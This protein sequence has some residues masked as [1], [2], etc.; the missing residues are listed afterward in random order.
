M[1]RLSFEA[2]GLSAPLCAALQS[3]GYSVPTPIQAQAVPELLAGRDLIGVARTGTGKTAAFALPLLQHLDGTRAAQKG[4]GPRALVLT[5]TRELAAQ[6]GESLRQYGRDMPLRTATVFG[7]VGMAPQVNALRRGVDVLVATPGRLLDLCRS[8]AAELGSVEVFVLDEADRM[9][10]MGFIHD[11]RRIAAALP[12]ARQSVLFS[13]TM[14]GPI[15]ALAA[16]LL[17]DPVRVDADPPAT[18]S[19]KVEQHVYHVAKADKRNLLVD[20]LDDPTIQRCLVFTRTK[21]GADRVG[22]HLRRCDIDAEAIHGDKRQGARERALRA[23]RDGRARV[24]VA[25]DVAARG[26]D[27]PEISHVVN[28]DLPN[29]PDQY[30]HRIGRTARAGRS[31]VALS[32]CAPEERDWLRDI[33]KR[34]REALEV[35]E[36]AFARALPPNRPRA[37]GAARRPR[38]RPVRAGR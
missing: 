1:T 31:G 15:V 25:T 38:G 9:L 23:F 7:G 30:V 24:L 29:E 35:V 26:L 22:K 5:P 27:V 8:G 16:G 20:L 10:D 2:L 19:Q 36:H 12:R 18:V 33:E 14:P 17:R 4:R 32:F 11:V 34:T 37:P 3:R 6:V 28:F 13:A 21:H